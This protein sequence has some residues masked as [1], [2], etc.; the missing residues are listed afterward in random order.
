MLKIAPSTVSRSLADHPDISE[1]TK[2]KVRTLAE[3]LGYKPNHFAVNFRRQHSSLIALILPEITMFFFPEVIRA[4]EEA[5][6][7]RG[8]SLI[9]LHSQNSLELEKE[10]LELCMQFSVDGI[11]L[12]LSKETTDLEHIKALTNF[13]LP[14]V[15]FDRILPSDFLST[16]TIDDRKVAHQAVELLIKKGHRKIC[17]MFGYENLYIS[18]ERYQGF[19]NAMQKYDLKVREDWV[20]NTQNVNTIMNELTLVM[21]GEDRPTA[22]F[23]MSDE[24]LIGIYQVMAQL[25]LKIPEDVAII[26]ISEGYIPN[27]FFPKVTYVRHSGYE[28]GTKASELLLEIMGN[29]NSPLLNEQIVPQ[30][31]IQHSV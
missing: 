17:G 9:V 8:F 6:K 12:S 14:I 24:L 23:A 16:L 25:N 27:F 19:L 30:L 11:L 3:E 31:V 22:V 13:D 1:K 10:N 18:K 20:L 26:C 7:N 5:V 15:L 28:V 4:V 2:Q 29:S 21:A